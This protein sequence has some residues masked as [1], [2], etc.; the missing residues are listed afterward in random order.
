MHGNPKQTQE[1]FN[2]VKESGLQTDVIIL[3]PLEIIIPSKVVPEFSVLA[4]I[5]LSFGMGITVY[6][7]RNKN[8]VNM[9]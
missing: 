1:F 6:L 7:L 2:L 4:I 3:S 8:F 5:V 9:I